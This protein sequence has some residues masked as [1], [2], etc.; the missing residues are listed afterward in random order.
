MNKIFVLVYVIIKMVI[1]DFLNLFIA[2]AIIIFLSLITSRRLQMCRRHRRIHN[3]RECCRKE[4]KTLRDHLSV[5]N[6]LI[7]ADRRKILELRCTELLHR[8]KSRDL[9]AVDVLE[10]YQSAAIA[11][12]ED[13][14][15]VTQ[16][17]KEAKDWAKQLDASSSVKPLH[18]VPI[19]LKENII[20]SGYDTTIG[21]SK[22]LTECHTADS[23]IVKIL[24][25][26]GAVPF[27][28]TNLPQLMASIGCSNPIYGRTLHPNDKTRTP[29]GSSGGE[30]AL[31]GSGGSIVGVGT[32]LLGSCR[33]PASFCGVVGLKPTTNRL[34]LIGALSGRQGGVGLA[35]I[36]GLLGKNVDIVTEVFKCLTEGQHMYNY[37]RM[38]PPITYSINDSTKLK[39]GYY[40]D[41]DFIPAI[42]SVKNAVR[43][44]IRR[45]ANAGH[46]VVPFTLPSVDSIIKLILQ[47]ISSDGSK[48]FQSQWTGEDIDPCL[49]SLYV[50]SIIPSFVKTIASIILKSKCPQV[51]LLLK[52]KSLNTEELQKCLYKRYVLQQ[53]VIK[54][55]EEAE[56]D[57]L[58]TPVLPVVAIPHNIISEL[59]IVSVYTGIYNFLDFPSGSVPVG[60]VTVTDEADIASYPVDGNPLLKMIKNGMKGIEGLP[61]SVQVV[62]LPYEDEKVL[63]AMKTVES[64]CIRK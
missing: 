14:N 59:A 20:I 57:V 12:T 53:Q 7:T 51:S 58:I 55:W 40:T 46:T 43:D 38:C 52:M 25:A 22:Y 16:F 56:L 24:K 3:R 60:S 32:D 21:I 42:S 62:G 47:F 45:L 54:T 33:I 17:I 29:G 41:L 31:I 8:L 63:N 39:I 26:L 5:Q 28:R 10:A 11:A 44:T 23:N 15:C 2:V 1:F 61:L 9:K 4:L 6:V 64:I 49:R 34:S 27:C 37:D 18:G 13:L 30:G 36:L 50:S 48:Y 19:S 35:E